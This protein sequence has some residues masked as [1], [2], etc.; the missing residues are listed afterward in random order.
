MKDLLKWIIYVGIGLI[1][2]TP[3]IIGSGTFFPYIVN[4]AYYFRIITEIIFFTWIILSIIDVKYRP[5]K[6]PILIS[7]LVFTVV[8]FISNVFGVNSF[9]SFWS[10]YERM[11]GFIT[12]LHLLAL[13]LVSSSVLD[14]DAWRKIFNISIFLSLFMVMKSFVEINE[15]GLDRRVVATLGNSTYLGIYA[16][17]H[18]FLTLYVANEYILR[19]G[20]DSLKK[21]IKNPA[22]W[23]YIF[24][25]I[26]N[27]YIVFQTG[28][29][30]SI[31]GWF[32]G[33]MLIGLLIAYFSKGK[34]KQKKVAAYG[35]VSVFTLFAILLFLK[36]TQLIQNIQPLKRVTNISI[37]EGTAQARILNWQMALDGFKERPILGW[38]QGN[39]SYVFD[40]YYLPAHHGNEVWFDRVHNVILDWLINGGLVGLVAYLS[41]WFFT[42]KSIFKNDEMSDISK[43]IFISLLAAYFF[44]NLF[45]FDQIGSYIYFFLFL[46]F[47]HSFNGKGFNFLDVGIPEWLKYTKIVLV[48]ILLP[49]V[50]YSANVPSYTANTELIEA[51]KLTK[52]NTDGSYSYY[53]EEGLGGNVAMFRQA[54]G[55]ETLGNPEIRQRALLLLN[56][57]DKINNIDSS[58]RGKY[59][60]MVIEEFKKQIQEDPINSKYPYMLGAFYANL[61]QFNLA[62]EYMLQGINLS[63]TKQAIRYP[64]IQLYNNTNQKAKAISFSK[65]TYE[66]DTS[67]DETWVW[68]VNTL[69]RFEPNL[70]DE[71][72]SQSID[73]GET[74]R[75]EKI[76][77]SSISK[78][79]EN[80][81]AYISLAAFYMKLGDTVKS[82]DVLYEVIER[83]PELENQI[84]ILI[85]KI[86]NG[87]N[88]LGESF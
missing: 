85:D 16:L 17:M 63:P 54:I 64:L 35:V 41:I 25:F 81:Q 57:I 18:A 86:E 53:Y 43:S 8:T 68:Y 44:H 46:A 9:N 13:F 73:M 66:L 12:I 10:N 78:N 42:I 1:L 27:S 19:K 55:K 48:I 45:V 80:S 52:Q 69:A 40:K 32:G 31:L 3:F 15:Y 67:K 59:I 88:P 11:E 50:I 47:I 39:F 82:I 34:S 51:L 75:V 29:R 72:I 28:T 61:G 33:L 62:E 84:N 49:V 26:L 37:T 23:I 14:R 6:G 87:E 24:S 2:Y 76:L 36:D 7:L 70:V 58:E 71:V 21:Y 79:P 60:E 56:S 38:G 5:K 83:F 65:E 20:L 22:I 77:M 30:G 4:K 74:D